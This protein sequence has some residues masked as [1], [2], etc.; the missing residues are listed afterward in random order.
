MNNTSNESNSVIT[1]DEALGWK[2]DR[3]T[4]KFLEVLDDNCKMI[5]MNWGNKAYTNEENLEASALKNSEMLGE[6]RAYKTIIQAFNE[7]KAIPYTDEEV[8][9]A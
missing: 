8:D 1:R 3:C 2:R 6:L 5:M 9:N 7:G 4:R